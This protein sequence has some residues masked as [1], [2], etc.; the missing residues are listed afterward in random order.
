MHA[1]VCQATE[2][3]GTSSIVLIDSQDQIH[4]EAPIDTVPPTYQGPENVLSNIAAKIPNNDLGI[5]IMLGSSNV[6]E[7]LGLFVSVINPSRGAIVRRGTV[8]AQYGVGKFSSKVQ[9]DKT[10]QFVFGNMDMCVIFKGQIISLLDLLGAVEGDDFTA[11][12][13]GH[14]MRLGL[15]DPEHESV[16]IE[17][18][19]DGENLFV[20]HLEEINPFAPECLGMYANDLAFR[21]GISEKEYLNSLSKNIL[22]IVWEVELNSDRTMIIPKYPLLVLA[23]DTLFSNTVPMEMGLS[24]SW[25]Y[26]EV[27]MEAKSRQEGR[28]R[29]WKNGDDDDRD[30]GDEADQVLSSKRSS[31]G[32]S[33]DKGGSKSR[34]TRGSSRRSRPAYSE[35]DGEWVDG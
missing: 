16:L 14:R 34:A 3:S 12:I 17:P 11:A 13:W 23:R 25:Y 33:S 19:E 24:Y 22:K 26:W 28:K 10:V 5:N 31:S 20:P 8:M 7:G 18:L 15:L 21:R 6:A 27:E 35:S 29:S 30:E 4:C 1:I 32:R 9:G 2:R